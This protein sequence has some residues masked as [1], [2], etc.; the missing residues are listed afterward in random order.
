MYLVLASCYTLQCDI[1]SWCWLHYSICAEIWFSAFW[2]PH[3][4]LDEVFYSHLYHSKFCTCCQAYMNGPRV[5]LLCGKRALSV[6]ASWNLR[7]EANFEKQCEISF[8]WCFVHMYIDHNLF[9]EILMNVQIVLSIHVGKGCQAR[10]AC[11]CAS[12]SVCHACWVIVLR[13]WIACVVWYRVH[14]AIRNLHIIQTIQLK[15]LA[16]KSSVPQQVS[17][18]RK[19][20]GW[21]C[22]NL[23]CYIEYLHVHKWLFMNFWLLV[24]KKHS[25]HLS[26]FS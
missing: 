22:L 20:Y 10:L 1:P 14:D 3:K 17:R 2:L 18:T 24:K 21:R 25:H 5:P 8:V 13:V 11:Y 15:T 9:T 23:P 4:F 26:T 16:G 7:R 12:L 6:H 19:L